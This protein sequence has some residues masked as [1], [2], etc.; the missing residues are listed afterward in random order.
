MAL[1]WWDKEKLD[2]PV[3][4]LHKKFSPFHYDMKVVHLDPEQLDPLVLAAS[5]AKTSVGYYVIRYLISSH[6]L[7]VPMWLLS[8]NDSHLSA[9]YCYK[10]PLGH[11]AYFME[12]LNWLTSPKPAVISEVTGI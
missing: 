3:M 12:H 7:K 4:F 9:P 5:E 1:Q 2:H 6:A 8:Q 11:W 10:L